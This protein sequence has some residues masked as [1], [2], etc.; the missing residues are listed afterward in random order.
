MDLAPLKILLVVLETNKHEKC[1]YI[2]CSMYYHNVHNYILKMID[3]QLRAGLIFICMSVLHA[4]LSSSAI[5]E[6]TSSTSVVVPSPASVQLV[7]YQ[8][9]STEG[10]VNKTS[11]RSYAHFG[12]HTFSNISHSLMYRLYISKNHPGSQQC[13]SALHDNTSDIILTLM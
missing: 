13:L 7:H 11:S 6:M 5:F 4:Q 9:H 10:S 1:P 8:V 12:R 2:I 3:N